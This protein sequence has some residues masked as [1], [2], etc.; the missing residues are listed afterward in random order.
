MISVNVHSVDV[1]YNVKLVFPVVI[2]AHS[3]VTRVLMRKL[4]VKI[5]VEKRIQIVNINVIDD[6]ILKQNVYLV[7]KQF[8]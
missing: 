5:L 8:V 2:D 3:L 7:M 6:A 4:F 1:V